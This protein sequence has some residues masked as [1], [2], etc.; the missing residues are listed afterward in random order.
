MDISADK[1]IYPFMLFDVAWLAPEILIAH[2]LESGNTYID[3]NKADIYSYGIVF[4][5]IVT[6]EDPY[7]DYNNM[8]IG[9]LVTGSDLRPEIPDFVPDA[10][11]RIGLTQCSMIL[12]QL[13]GR[14]IQASA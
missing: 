12:P 7:P 8:T 4:Y 5:E 3:W 6:R 13:A 14:K 11:V 2:R 1:K 9:I 10:L